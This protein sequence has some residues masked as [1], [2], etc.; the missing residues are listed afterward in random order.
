MRQLL[1]VLL[2]LQS[3]IYPLAQT[4]QNAIT[5]QEQF[6]QLAKR[7]T[8]YAHSNDPDSLKKYGKQMWN[9]AYQHGDPLMIVR[10]INVKGHIFEKEGSF[11]S[12]FYYYQ[13]GLKMSS[14]NGFRGRQKFIFNRLGMLHYDNS[15][16]NKA[17]RYHLESLRMREEDGNDNEIAYACNNIGLVYYRINDQ[18]KAIF[19]LKKAL[20]LKKS[21]NQK[22]TSTLVN[23]GLCY[24]SLK[25]HEQAREYYGQVIGL[26]KLDCPEDL[27]EAYIG[28]AL[29]F[30]DEEN[31]IKSR[32]YFEK[33][34]GL[35]EE[36]QFIL[37]LIV[38]YFYLSTIQQKKDAFDEALDLSKISLKMARDHRKPEWEGYN[39]KQLAQIYSKLNDHRFAYRYYVKYDSINSELLNKGIIKDMA[40]IQADYEEY[41]N[42][43]IIDEQGRE[44]T[45]RTTYLTIIL[46]LFILVTLI[47]IIL[48]RNNRFRKRAHHQISET[49]EEL[50]AAQDKLV[51][52]ERQTAMNGVVTS[53][54]H[55][56][57]SPLG[58]VRALLEPLNDSFMALSAACSPSEVQRTADTGSGSSLNGPVQLFQKHIR[59]VSEMTERM[60]SLV[61]TLQIHANPDT[62]L[63]TSGQVDLITNIQTALEDFKLPAGIRLTARFPDTPVYV[64]GDGTAMIMAWKNLI[65]NALEAIADKGDI[66]I[67]LHTEEGFAQVDFKDSAGLEHG[68]KDNLFEPFYTT[69]EDY[70]TGLGLTICRTVI[71]NHGG[72]I[73][74]KVENNTTVFIVKL[75][76]EDD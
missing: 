68:V 58:A 75:P 21:L 54:A 45:T 57:N 5:P 8:R 61:K 6:D 66:V 48:Y 51:H 55:Q 40:S 46:V 36:H 27:A 29:S 47:V 56:L 22:I 18:D 30:L 41:Q 20:G 26:C 32:V 73:T 4:E 19:Y 50:R 10:A 17:L 38:S 15:M 34:I 76:L 62:M 37:R 42:K 24:T 59:Y 60:A 63:L 3:N 9:L 25:K 2:A 74:Y 44:I 11:D 35:S 69:K 12:A 13:E 31:Y 28:L 67:D 71:E 64:K 65:Q 70:H 53:L 49:M 72:T 43:K 39:Y 1:V 33:C 23:L 14:A 52:Q 7:F 16:Y